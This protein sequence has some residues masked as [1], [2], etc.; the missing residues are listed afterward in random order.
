MNR[1]GQP[2]QPLTS[3]KRKI[4]W[5][6]AD[7]EVL[8]TASNWKEGSDR[9]IVPIVMPA[10]SYQDAVRCLQEELPKCG[11]QLR[12]IDEI[13]EFETVEWKALVDKELYESLFRKA[14]VSRQIQFGKFY[15]YSSTDEDD[16]A[17]E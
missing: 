17:P 9:A 14:E 13:E 4:R 7:V 8:P 11:Y 16:E 15:F 5:V 3:P 1:K 12:Y 6:L 10:F 2:Y